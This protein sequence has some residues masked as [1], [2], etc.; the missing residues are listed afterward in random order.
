MPVTAVSISLSIYSPQTQLDS[1]G[2]RYIVQALLFTVY[3]LSACTF[4][5]CLNFKNLEGVPVRVSVTR[6]TN[7]G[8][9]NFR[10]CTAQHLRLHD[11]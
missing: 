1:N 10:T 8:T 7:F 6:V 2:C 4:L 11:E 9:K 3:R 5:I